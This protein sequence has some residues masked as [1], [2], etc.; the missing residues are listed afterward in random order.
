MK[1]LILATLAGF[2]A[3]MVSG[4]IAYMLFYQDLMTEMIAT[5]PE[6]MN[7]ESDQNFLVGMGVGLAQA[8]LMTYSFDKMNFNTLKSGALNGTWF[9]GGIWLVA[10]MNNLFLFKFYDVSLMMSDTL[11]SA[12]FG[13]LAGGAIGWTL[14]KLK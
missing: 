2:V 8:I 10:N 11:I 13:L 7:S 5:Y 9:S 12:A 1:K 6:S 3:S 14:D 4:M